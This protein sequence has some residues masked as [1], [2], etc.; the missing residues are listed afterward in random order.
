MSK[1][2]E[3]WG[4]SSIGELCE[5]SQYGWTTKASLTATTGTK[6]LRTTD[7]SGETIKWEA[8]PYCSE[9]P[10]DLSKYLLK[11]GDIVISRAGSIG[12]S[13]LIA[14]PD[15]AV[16]AS[17]LIRFVPRPELNTKYLG[18]FL[19]SPDYWE[20]IRESA[21]GIA[22][23]NVNAKKLS[24][25]EVPV[26]PFPEQGRIVAELEKQ[27]TRLDAATAALKRVQ[28]NLKRYRVSVL[29]AACEGRLV[30]TE[31]E[32]ARTE[33]RDYEPADKLLQRILRERRARWEADTLAKMQASGKAPKDDLWKHKYKEP[34]APDTS[35]LPTLPEG[36]C[37]ASVEQISTKVV[38]GVHQKPNYV[39]EGVPFITVKNLTAG[40]G[41]SF[42]R[43][44]F[45][46][47]ENHDEFIRRADPERGDI[48]VSKDGTLGKIRAVRTDETF[49]IFVSVAMIKPVILDTSDF[50]ELALTSPQVQIQMVPKGSGLQHIH[51]E[52]LREDCIP[53]APLSE[54]SRIV[55][56]CSRLLTLMDATER[57]V[58]RNIALG[59]ATRSSILRSAFTG[60]LVPQDPTDE[61]ASALLERIRAERGASAKQ[62][63]TRRS[64]KDPAHA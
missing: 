58:K 63:P 19:K 18:Y 61:P 30:L 16:F 27:F 13:T 57:T 37:W 44:N 55:G 40:P 31:A 6:F 26:A 38:D 24:I 46:T 20:A 25:I 1:L 3:S 15:P 56:E 29:K 12:L 59:A 42:E 9:V 32:L 60:Q 51:L 14:N 52:D 39:S 47:Q 43:T 53:L 35:N 62:K 36:W 10:D 49:S 21:S 54:Q 23:Q 41:I 48:L 34:S 33:G 28:A 64:R 7:I 5:P 17:Y 4:L 45:I 22:L 11:N 8:V 50:L 2:P